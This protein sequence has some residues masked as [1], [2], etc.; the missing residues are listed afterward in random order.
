M[1]FEGSFAEIRQRTLFS[2]LILISSFC[3]LLKFRLFG[4]VVGFL[5]ALGFGLTADG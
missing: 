1:M 4:V 2:S 5:T 3:R